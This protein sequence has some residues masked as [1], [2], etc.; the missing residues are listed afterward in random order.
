MASKYKAGADFEAGKRDEV[1]DR[2][3]GE[4]N[5]A[6]AGFQTYRNMGLERSIPKVSE[7]LGKPK[8]TVATWSSRFSWLMRAAAWDAELDRRDQ[9]WLAEQRRRALTRHVRQAQMLQSKWLGAMATLQPDKLSPA[10]VI[11]WAEVAT[12]MEREALELAGADGAGVTVNITALSPEDTL[13]RLTDLQ[14]EIHER[15]TEVSEA[16][17]KTNTRK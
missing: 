3:T 8:T 15:M 2:M 13:V 11:R 14:R 1:W 12:R 4:H 17:H 9:L 6:W 5:D 16:G 10:D 7:E